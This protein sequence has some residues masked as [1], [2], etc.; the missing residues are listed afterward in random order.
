MGSEEMR[1][2]QDKT[3][4]GHSV[5][6]LV[7]LLYR[8]FFIKVPKYGHCGRQGQASGHWRKK[9]KRERRKSPAETETGKVEGGMEGE[10]SSDRAGSFLMGV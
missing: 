9:K 7:F 10:F 1:G 5:A 3:R 6:R 8:V 2:R 4:Q